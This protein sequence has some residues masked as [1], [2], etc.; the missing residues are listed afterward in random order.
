MPQNKIYNRDELVDIVNS[1]YSTNNLDQFYLL[2]LD[3]DNSKKIFGETIEDRVI[4][5]IVNEIKEVFTTDEI[6]RIGRDT[7]AIFSRDTNILQTSRKKEEL[8]INISSK[9]DTHFTFCM[10]LGTV[11]HDTR[12]TYDRIAAIYDAL[13]SAKKK[14]T[15]N[16]ELVTE[17]NMKMKSFYLRKSQ[18]ERL[19]SHCKKENLS[20]ALII[21]KALDQ[22]LDKHTNK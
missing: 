14:Q 18:L 11:N 15:D 3:I 1:F 12:T 8:Q 5:V 7:F 19:S 21:R 13:F 22:Y 6:Y 2:L 17:E 20:E 4:D 16:I 9:I 10:G